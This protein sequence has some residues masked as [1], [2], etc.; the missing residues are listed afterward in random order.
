MDKTSSYTLLM[1]EQLKI[2]W[3]EY[4]DKVIP[5]VFMLLG[6]HEGLLE[7]EKSTAQKYGLHSSDFRTLL[8]L[9]TISP[10][11]VLSP[12]VLLNALGITSG[13]LTKVLHRLTDQGLVERIKNPNDNRSTL[14]RVTPKGDELLS[15]VMDDLYEQDLSLVSALSDEER[16][17][18]QGICKKF[19]NHLHPDHS[20]LKK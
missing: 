11:K 5:E 17:V 19:L 15:S 9:R 2:N 6:I 20:D 14:V 18:L 16:H 8:H 13:G 12:S 7:V 1:L 4:K 3:P 10:D